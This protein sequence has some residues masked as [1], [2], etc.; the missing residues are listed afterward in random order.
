MKGSRKMVVSNHS[1][2]H[3]FFFLKRGYHGSHI[4]VEYL[5]YVVSFSFSWFPLLP[6]ISIRGL[7]LLV[8]LIATFVQ[9]N[10]DNII[11]TL[12]VVA[13]K[14]MRLCS[15]ITD[16]NTL[17]DKK[18]CLLMSVFFYVLQFLILVSF[19]I[20][21]RSPIYLIYPSFYIAVSL[22]LGL[23]QLEYLPTFQAHYLYK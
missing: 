12:S 9:Q 19:Q 14:F 3:S 23:G 11:N 4:K 7:R 5:Y 13:I 16:Y 17:Y 8:M 2:N 22:L 20:I 21:V 1:L 6:G 15:F 10:N 18:I